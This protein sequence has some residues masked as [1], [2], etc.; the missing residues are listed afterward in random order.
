MSVQRQLD[1]IRDG[2]LGKNS[3]RSYQND[4]MFRQSLNK[5]QEMCERCKR[6]SNEFHWEYG[7]MQNKQQILESEKKDMRSLSSKLKYNV[8]ILDRRVRDVEA[9]VDHFDRKLED[10]RKKLLEQNNSKD[11]SMALESPCD[12][13]EFDS[14]MDSIVQSQ[15]TKYEGL[16]FKI[17]D[18]KSL[19]KLKR[20]SGN[21]ALGHSIPS[22]TKIG[23]IRRKIHYESFLISLLLLQIY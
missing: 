10:V 4:L 1:E 18:K 13:F 3:Q 15:Q 16:C 22:Y 7:N 5:L 21:G 23:P 9:S 2:Y 14:F 12:K 17:L 6:G 8:R 19:R 11:I 20:N